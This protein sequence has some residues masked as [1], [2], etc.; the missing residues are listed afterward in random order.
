MKKKYHYPRPQLYRESFQLLDGTWLLNHQLIQVPYPP[1]APLSQYQG[2][3]G[4]HHHYEKTFILDKQMSGKEKSVHLHFGAVDQ[5]AKVYM[6]HQ[7]VGEHQGGYLPF[8]FDITAFIQEGEN[9]LEVEVTDQ[10][11]TLYPYGKQKK[12]SGGM[13]YTPVSGIWQSVWLE[14]VNK[15][16]IQ[17][18]RITPTLEKIH[19]HVETMAS[20]YQVKIKGDTFFFQDTFDQ[21]DIDIEIP[22]EYRHYWSEDNPYLYKLIIDTDDDHIESYFALRTIEIKNEMIL[23]NQKPIFLHGVL[24]QGYFHDGLFLP[25]DMDGYEKDIIKMKELG[26]NCIRK[27]IKIEP[28]AFYYA[29]DCLGMLVIQDHVNNGKYHYIGDTVLPNLG[30][31]YRPDFMMGKQVQKYIFQKHMME[32]LKHL[33][34]HPCIIGYT[35]FNEG[36]GQIQADEMYQKCKDYDST[37]F[38]DAT[39][40][41]FHQK[42]SN[43]Q[44]EHVYFRNKIIKN[45][46]K[47]P[48][49]LSECGGYTRAIKDHVYAKKQYG[50]GK[51]QSEKELTNRIIKL[52][53]EMVIPSIPY[54]LCGCIYT[55]LSDIEDE[56]NG[57]YTYDRQICKVNKERLLE[58]QKKIHQEFNLI[59]AKKIVE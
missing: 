42:L 18:L 46:Q 5:I 15:H 51:A 1:Q 33:Y 49:L 59:H 54:G 32:T 53:E 9:L 58:I 3:I 20:S 19:L 48:V 22:E 44:S 38:Y 35:I 41:W 2:E 31:K 52:Y 23:L 39:S 7:C 13:W 45:K 43:V 21:K 47:R 17:D 27:H 16:Y 37:R 6:N 30:F 34:N 11:S 56:I 12:K 8:W 4:E 26:F 50:Y 40:G 28:E 57:L 36:W 14:A 29:C 55:Q 25:S 10:L 24:D